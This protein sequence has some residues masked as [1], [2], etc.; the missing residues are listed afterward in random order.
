M[1][2]CLPA[3][4]PCCCVSCGRIPRW[5]VPLPKLVPHAGRARLATAAPVFQRI[6]VDDVAQAAGIAV[7][8]AGEGDSLDTK[9]FF[10]LGMLRS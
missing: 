9:R 4:S 8:N 10:L 7:Q 3:A 2:P 6:S 1:E 5:G